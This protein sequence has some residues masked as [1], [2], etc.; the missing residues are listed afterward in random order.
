MYIMNACMMDYFY[1]GI[2]EYL[3]VWYSLVGKLNMVDKIINAAVLSYSAA[4]LIFKSST[5]DIQTYIAHD[6]MF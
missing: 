1:V 4:N 3:T 5:I 2:K 6:K